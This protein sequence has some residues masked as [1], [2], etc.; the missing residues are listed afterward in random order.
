MFFI[1][2]VTHELVGVK[3]VQS[4]V[5]IMLS[6]NGL[7]KL[8]PLSRVGRVTT[9]FRKHILIILKIIDQNATNNLILLDII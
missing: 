7:K 9:L 8:L 4:H 2:N 3:A 6:I 5:C 1:L